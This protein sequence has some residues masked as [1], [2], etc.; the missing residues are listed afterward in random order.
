MYVI[1]ATYVSILYE[2]GTCH[3]PELIKG[4]PV[5]LPSQM[6]LRSFRFHLVHLAAF[7]ISAHAFIQVIDVLAS[8]DIHATGENLRDPLLLN[9]KSLPQWLGATAVTVTCDHVACQAFR[10]K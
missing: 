8:A 1:R 7:G 9:L 4:A 3:L 5:R 6:C 2:E 10:A